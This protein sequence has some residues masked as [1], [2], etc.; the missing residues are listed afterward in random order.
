VGSARGE[1]ARHGTFLL[2]LL[3][4]IDPAEGL[5]LVLGAAGFALGPALA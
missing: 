2:G 1:P 4:G 5:V 3:A